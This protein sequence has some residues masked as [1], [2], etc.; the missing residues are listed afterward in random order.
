MSA[1]SVNHINRADGTF[2]R[3]NAFSFELRLPI[4]AVLKGGGSSPKPINPR[5]RRLIAVRDL[6]GGYHV[7]ATTVHGQREGILRL[8][9]VSL[10]PIRSRGNSVLDIGDVDLFESRRNL[11][12]RVISHAISCADHRL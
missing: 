1:L 5:P 7:S 11:Q 2:R 8:Q 9:R 4:L 12:R 3:A 6:R 10:V